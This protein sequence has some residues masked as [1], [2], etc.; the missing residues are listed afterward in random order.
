VIQ[1]TTWQG[2]LLLALLATLSWIVNRESDDEV[3]RPATKLDLRLNFALSDF[4]ARL[5]DDGG[6]VHMQIQAPALRSDAE[7]GQSTVENPE[8]LIRQED[9]QWNITAESAIITADREHV[10]L[11]GEV[12]LVRKNV[13]TGESLEISTKD[14]MLNVTLR[15]ASTDSEVN[16]RHLNNRLD[17]IGME[18]DMIANSFKLKKDVRGYYETP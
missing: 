1:R 4:N 11:V 8:V 7:T 5:L 10:T 16:I 17:A 12:D 9:E 3:V 14:V 2:I 6:T 15:T 18:I 13:L